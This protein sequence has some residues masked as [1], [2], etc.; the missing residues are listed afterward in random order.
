MSGS[1]FRSEFGRISTMSNL[2]D[3]FQRRVQIRQL[4]KKLLH[5]LETFELRTT[6]YGSDAT[7]QHEW[8]VSSTTT[9]PALIEMNKRPG[10]IVGA[11]DPIKSCIS[12]LGLMQDLPIQLLDF[13]ASI[14]RSNHGCFVTPL[15][16]SS[17]Q[18]KLAPHYPATMIESG[19][20]VLERSSTSPTE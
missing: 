17:N 4:V 6:P 10:C 18:M 15:A 1:V 2:A 3:A 5:S 16:L 20:K 14:F 13:Q 9:L 19:H 8:Q 12:D 11:I 7:P